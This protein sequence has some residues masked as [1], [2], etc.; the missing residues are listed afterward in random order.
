[1]RR[2]KKGKLQTQILACYLC[3][4][5]FAAAVL[6]GAAVLFTRQNEESFLRRMDDG[7]AAVGQRVEANTQFLIELG[8]MIGENTL[9]TENFR[10]YDQL[11][12]QQL[13]YYNSI[14]NLL[15]QSRLQFDS[16]VDSIFLYADDQRVLYSMKERG[17][18]RLDTFFGS[19]MRFG[20]YD[21]A[22][23]RA[24]LAEGSAMPFAVLPADTYTTGYVRDTHTVIPLIFAKSNHG[25]PNVLV[26]NLDVAK[27]AAAYVDGQLFSA[28]HLLIYDDE[29][30]LLRGPEGAPDA[31]A[32][33]GAARLR[34]QGEDCYVAMN[35]QS[36]LGVT[37]WG[38]TP[39]RTFLSMTAYFRFT[40]M[41]VCAVFILCGVAMALLMSRR[42][43]A[44]IRAIGQDIRTAQV[45][46]PTHDEYLSNEL[47]AI[48]VGITQLANE[49]EQFRVR[50]RQ[51]SQHYLAQSLT[52]L[53]DGRALK[54]E[55]YFA[56]LLESEYGFQ[57]RS[58]LCAA[59][60]L[61]AQDRDDYP[62]QS[63]RMA[64]LM[65][66]VTCL[67]GGV[68]AM[69]P[70]P[71]QD[72]MLVLLLDAGSAAEDV[73]RGC[74]AQ[75]AEGFQDD[76]C[77]LRT[78][79]GGVA[80]CVADIPVSF[81]QALTEVFAIPAEG[82]LAPQGEDGFT[83]DRAEI[84][85][86]ANTRDLKRIAD[87]AEDILTQ[88]KIHRIPYGEA[89]A[90]TRDI[91]ETVMDIQRRF[92]P[93]QVFAAMAGGREAFSVMA[94]LILSPEINLAPMLAVLLRHIPYQGGNHSVKEAER[95][96]LRAKEWLDAHYHETVS[97]DILADHIGV[98]SKYLS[99]IFKQ[100]MGV[101]LSDYLAYVRVERIK[102]LLRTG[103]SLE[104]I[105]ESVGFTNRTTF[106]RTFKKLEGMT[107]SEWRSLHAG[108]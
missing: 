69:A 76:D 38:L 45:A 78:G 7:M 74:V 95:I 93:G 50:N 22:W 100:E 55:R 108:E 71:Y 48:R 59:L 15:Y 97:L 89:A 4:A 106:I 52:A 31:R 3:M 94:V 86:A 30:R 29:G 26:M 1:M 24:R 85:A 65:E 44:P 13:Y 37:V 51:H 10:P 79:M 53:L 39:V 28:D 42:T 107:P 83:Y 70:L 17:M 27:L 8:V 104:A 21:A 82:D 62:R 20:R 68:A 11:R 32:L 35:R 75:A 56:A 96:A 90:V 57:G 101:N 19:F 98:S 73:L 63:E 77:A 66:R 61:D 87:A 14:I 47:E 9:V 99:R 81:E 40:V 102:A 41:A 92:A 60:I 12:G 64:Q 67:L 16:M 58:Y 49:R 103:S 105:A 25:E 33:E 84:I 54:D 88:A 46:P 6:L 23:W 43:Y 34:F 72:N 80:Q 91:F 2:G 18:T 36:G 5:F